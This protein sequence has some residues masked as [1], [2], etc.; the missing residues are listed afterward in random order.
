MT[1]YL[2]GIDCGCTSIKAV[3][4][5]QTGNVITTASKS[6]KGFPRRG[7]EFEEFDVEDQWNSAASCIKSVIE[8]AGLTAGTSPESAS[9]PLATAVPYWTRSA[10]PPSQV[11]FPRI[12]GP[13]AS[14][15]ATKKRGSWPALTRS[16]R[17]ACILASP[18]RC[19]AGS[20]TTNPRRMEKLPMFCYSRTCWHSISPAW[21]REI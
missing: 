21:L 10:K 17:A 7:P 16:P 3:I 20:R 15:P 4:F 6:S 2:I 14:S 18:A 9:P 8:K 13:M 1:K 5:D 19:C 12:T 11:H